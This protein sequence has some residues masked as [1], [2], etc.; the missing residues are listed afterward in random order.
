MVSAHVYTDT[1]KFRPSLAL[2]CLN[3][4]QPRALSFPLNLFVRCCGDF[5]FLFVSFF[6]P[7]VNVFCHILHAF[8]YSLL[9]CISYGIYLLS[10]HVHSVSLSFVFCWFPEPDFQHLVSRLVYRRLCNFLFLLVIPT[11]ADLSLE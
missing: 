1:E 9:T 5:V 11:I 8:F 4:R 7:Y 6:V 2:Q 10:F 3:P